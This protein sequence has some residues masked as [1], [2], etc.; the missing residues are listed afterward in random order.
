LR[1]N[2]TA[3]IYGLYRADVKAAIIDGDRCHIFTCSRCNHSVNRFLE[4]KDCGSTSNLRL[5]AKG[6]WGKDVVSRL[7]KTKNLHESRKAA[8]G[9][10]KTGKL[11]EYFCSQKGDHIVTYQQQTLTRMEMRYVSESA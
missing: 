9:F 7:E 5:H 8:K 1:K 10:L 4:T 2:W 6:C 11:T 3:P